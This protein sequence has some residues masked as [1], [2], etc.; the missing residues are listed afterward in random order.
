M[1]QRPKSVT[2]VCWVFLIL[3]IVAIL[4]S[5]LPKSQDT[6]RSLLTYRTAHP[7]S[8]FYFWASPILCAI[9]A[10]LMLK[11]INWARW[12]FV[13]WIGANMVSK[14]VLAPSAINLAGTIMFSIPVYFLFR[15]QSGKFFKS[16][17]VRPNGSTH[18]SSV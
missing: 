14:L 7:F 2:V 3:G 10:I 9:S 11:G 12:F 6:A 8:Y 1:N 13:L 15:P 5:F 17:L 16:E 4:V 18:G